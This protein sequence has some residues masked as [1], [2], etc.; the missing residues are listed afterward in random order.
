MTKLELLRDLLKS[1]L[2]EINKKLET[3]LSIYYEEGGVNFIILDCNKEVLMIEDIFIYDYTLDGQIKFI[4]DVGNKVA[5]FFRESEDMEYDKVYFCGCEDSYYDEDFYCLNTIKRDHNDCFMFPA[6]S[7]GYDKNK[8]TDEILYKLID[9]LSW[10]VHA[11]YDDNCIYVNVDIDEVIL[12]VKYEENNEISKYPL[13][14]YYSF[15]EEKEAEKVVKY[16]EKL[17]QK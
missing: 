14:V 11:G 12:N 5:T 13:V 9:K 1:N 8:L 6:Y 3:E 10:T 15:V 17:L 2:D 16:I 7:I 4:K